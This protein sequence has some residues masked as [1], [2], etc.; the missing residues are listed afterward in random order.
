[1]SVG[2]NYDA[3]KMQALE[4][5]KQNLAGQIQ[6]EVTALIENTVSNKQLEPNEAASIVQSVSAGKSL[7]S[8]SIGRVITIVEVYRTLPNKNKEVLVKIAYNSAMAKAAAK[9]GRDDIHW[10]AITN[11]TIIVAHIVAVSNS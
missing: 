10:L 6:T 1:M 11:F 9:S 3:A 5:A 7:I 4:L 8:Q 2:Q